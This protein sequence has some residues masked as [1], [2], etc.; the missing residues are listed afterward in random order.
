MMPIEELETQQIDMHS[1]DQT[2]A[3]EQVN[4]KKSKSSSSVP[5]LRL[6]NIAPKPEKVPVTVKSVGGQPLILVPGK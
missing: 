1:E 4:E 3:V 5:P 6:L 2:R